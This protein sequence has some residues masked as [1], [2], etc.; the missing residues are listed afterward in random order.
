MNRP[1]DP[2]APRVVVIGGGVAGLATA[3]MIRT[4]ARE[5]GADP[6]ITILEAQSHIGGATRTEKCD[7]FLCE[8]GP[9]GFLD[10]EPATLD[11]VKRLG[12]ESRLVKAS[13]HAAKRFI[14]HHG[15]MREVPLSPGAFL[16]SDILPAGAKLRMACELAIPAKRDLSDETV[17]DFARRRLGE[18]FAQYMIDPMVSGI[19][20]GNA[21]ELSLRA[22]F[23]KMVEMETEYGGLFRAMIAKQRAAKRNGKV[24]GGPGG[25]AATLTTFENGM[26]ELT[27][28]L[29]AELQANIITDAYVA[30]VVPRGDYYDVVTPQGAFAADSVV[31]ACPSYAAAEIVRG[32]SYNAAEAL[33]AIPYA[34]IDVI[35]HG[36]RT[37][38]VGHPLD[39]FGVLIPRGEEYRALGSLWC[40]AIF[41]NQAPSGTHLLRTMI[42][43]A[44]DPSVA[45]L[46]NNE[47]ESIAAQEHRRLFNVKREPIFHKL[48]RHPRGI[49]QYTRG[50]L[51]R[52]GELELLERQLPG[53][54][55]TGAAYRGVSVNGCIKDAYRVGN[56]LM[57]QWRLA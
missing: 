34:P 3:Y 38:D 17:Y 35:A 52:V 32:I 20:A 48:I 30:A 12:L 5:C 19:F 40:D 46:S 36:H 29:A 16:R 54:F 24:S 4:L 37:E 11:L 43:G 49:A 6:R 53:L 8:W 21:R 39:G 22:V 27:D 55:L 10:N 14:Y 15:K 50:H 26:G 25:A 9:N 28:S 33:S 2:L 44:H 31:V 57:T 56:A 42:G 51:D 47:V 45:K 23:P 7:G 13:A 18:S 1:A 41:P